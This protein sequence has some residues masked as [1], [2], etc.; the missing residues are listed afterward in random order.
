MA[1]HIK[2]AEENDVAFI[3]FYEEEERKPC[4]LDWDV[5]AE[6]SEKLTEIEEHPGKYTALVVQ[7]ES[8]KSFI[9]GANIA[10]LKT[11]N[12]E[13]IGAWVE[14]G[15]R[16]F[17]RIQNLPIPVIAKVARYA[18][19]GGLEI[20]MACDMIIAGENASFGQPEASLGVMPGW[21]GSYRLPMLVGPNRAK[22]MFM[23]GK[24]IDA[25][26]AYE[27]GLVNHVCEEDKLDQFVAE[28]VA[29]MAKNSAEVIKNVKHTIFDEMQVGIYHNCFIEATTSS[30]CMA[31]EDTK[32]RLADF[33]E[34][35][36][37]K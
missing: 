14:N 37:K 6:L 26:I 31:S 24:H 34:S 22:E 16:I 33:F 19:G 18:L 36:K 25:K 4:T 1:T 29:Q 11:Q 17:N 13:N 2:F 32:K 27:W 5:L 3:K 10:V 30:T 35:R 28:L 21:G 23:T 15:H 12:A 20:A 7:S 8:P 9:V